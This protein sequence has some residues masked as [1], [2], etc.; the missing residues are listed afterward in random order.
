MHENKATT[1]GRE[2]R[3]LNNCSTTGTDR[4]RDSG[5]KNSN[6]RNANRP[7]TEASPAILFQLSKV[8]ERAIEGRALA[9]GVQRYQSCSNLS[10][11][12]PA[13]GEHKLR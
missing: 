12:P 5:N 1:E 4:L 7:H 3:N 9:R 11:L 13:I 10:L 2:P 6:S 8:F